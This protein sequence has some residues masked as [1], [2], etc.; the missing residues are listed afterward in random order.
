MNK[1]CCGFKLSEL[2]KVEAGKID[3]RC[4]A[5]AVAVAPPIRRGGIKRQIFNDL[6]Q[7]LQKIS[8]SDNFKIK[9]LYLA[10]SSAIVVHRYCPLAYRRHQNPTSSSLLS[11]SSSLISLHSPVKEPSC[12]MSQSCYSSGSHLECKV[13]IL[14]V[15]GVIGQPLS[16]LMKLNPLVSSP[17]FYDISNTPGVAADVNHINS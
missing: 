9:S 15:A 6:F 17:P 16:L 7:G 11:L 14:G 12:L 8:L 10:L 4:M 5:V 1:Y 3:K 13:V 2:G